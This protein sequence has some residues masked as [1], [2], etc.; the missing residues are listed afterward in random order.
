[1][2]HAADDRLCNR[3][4][5]DTIELYAMDRLPE[6]MIREHLDTCIFCRKSVDECRSYIAVL[7][8][9]LHDL[10]RGQTHGSERQR[11]LGPRRG[12]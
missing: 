4:D 8:E 1:M 5:N 12:G 2:T 7:K 9:A 10:Q 3:I 6:G 11:R